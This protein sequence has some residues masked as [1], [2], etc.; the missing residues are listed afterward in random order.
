MKK[1]LL[2]LGLAAIGATSGHAQT[3]NAPAQG[4]APTATN[5]VPV[6]MT[7][8]ALPRPILQVKPVKLD[9]AHT[10]AFFQALQSVVSFP[11]NAVPVSGS[12]RMNPD[13][14]VTIFGAVQPTAPVTTQ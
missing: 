6:P 8:P 4:S 10:T 9:A 3:T 12:Y 11:T 7:A 1:L 13:G 5:L 14:T 2:I